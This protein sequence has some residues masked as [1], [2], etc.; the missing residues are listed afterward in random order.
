[1]LA[2]RKGEGGLGGERP[3]APETPP[4]SV[5]R[6]PLA[7]ESNEVATVTPSP[8]VSGDSRRRLGDDSRLIAAE[9]SAECASIGWYVVNRDVLDVTA[10]LASSNRLATDTTTQ[11]A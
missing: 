1:M 11:R 5:P 6:K 9:T 8:G 2:V 4:A 7:Q 3:V 10:L